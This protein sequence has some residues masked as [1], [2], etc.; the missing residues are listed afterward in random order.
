MVNIGIVANGPKHLIPSLHAYIDEIDIWISADGGT[1]TLLEYGIQVDYAIGDFDS[2]TESEKER[3]EK[4]VKVF[5]LYT[6]E[7]DKTDLELAVDQALVLKPKVIYLFGV[8]GGRMD[9]E[10]VNI[11]LLHV[12]KDK[13]IRG[14]IVDQFNEVELT[15]PGEYTIEHDA[16]YPHISFV[17]FTE[18]VKGITLTNFYYPLKEKTITWGSTLCISNKLI[19]KSGTFYYEAGILLVIKSRDGIC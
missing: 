12:L 10:L 4:M 11:Q 1:T 18:T 9:H 13:G 17:P 3:I 16:N 5:D 6:V 2:I 15:V 14:I 8:T 7:K 19:E